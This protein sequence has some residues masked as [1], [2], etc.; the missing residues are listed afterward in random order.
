MKITW[1][2]I[3]LTSITS[4]IAFP[5]N[6]Q[7][8]ESIRRPEWFDRF[9]FNAFSI[10]NNNEY[11][12]FFTYGFVH[13][14]WM[15]LFFNMFTL[16]FFGG[17]VEKTFAVLFGHWGGL[18]YLSFYFLAIGVSTLADFFK[19]KN[20]SHYNAVGASGAVSAVLFAA[21]LFRPDMKIMFVFIPIPITAWFFGFMFIAYSIFMAKR[22]RDNIGHSAHL[23]GALFGFVFPIIFNPQLFMYFFSNL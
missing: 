10:S 6:V 5:P 21:I 23:W 19:Y 8:I 7:S 16:Y 22:N 2:I 9:K 18:I 17:F 4:I 14:S 15:H 12:R 3:I 20:H 11:H 13:A 1:A